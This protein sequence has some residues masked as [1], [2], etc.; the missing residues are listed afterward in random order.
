MDVRCNKSEGCP[1]QHEGETLELIKS[2]I[3][4]KLFNQPSLPQQN[5]S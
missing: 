5:E 3:H 4:L 2:R 1:W